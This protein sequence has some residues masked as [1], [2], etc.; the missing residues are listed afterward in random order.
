[1][2]DRE[3]IQRWWRRDDVRA[4]LTAHYALPDRTARF[5]VV[6]RSKGWLTVADR[7]VEEVLDASTPIFLGFSVSGWADPKE[8]FDGDPVRSVI[9]FDL[10][11]FPDAFYDYR[12]LK[13]WFE[14]NDLQHA[15]YFTGSKGVRVVAGSTQESFRT[16]AYWASLLC[17]MLHIDTLDMFPYSSPDGWLQPAATIHRKSGLPAFPLDTVPDSYETLFRRAVDVLE[18]APIPPLYLEDLDGNKFITTVKKEFDSYEREDRKRL[19]RG[20]RALRLRALRRGYEY[21]G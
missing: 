13:A 11:N 18:G 2:K 7:S 15:V 16:V 3:L 21:R 5:I 20:A 6:G 12:E 10:D 9:E 17:T 8:V 1:M 14:R 19:E 4:V